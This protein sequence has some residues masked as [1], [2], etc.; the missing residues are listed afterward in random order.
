MQRKPSS[1]SPSSSSI[2]SSS[3]QSSEVANNSSPTSKYFLDRLYFSKTKYYFGFVYFIRSKKK[4]SIFR[5]FFSMFSSKTASVEAEQKGLQKTQGLT[6]NASKV[7]K[8][9]SKNYDIDTSVGKVL[10]ESFSSRAGKLKI[11]Y[12][13]THMYNILYIYILI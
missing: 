5:S 9:E 12:I 7:S 3:L 1:L 4:K 11:D 2:S 13:H 8:E 6:S 10:S